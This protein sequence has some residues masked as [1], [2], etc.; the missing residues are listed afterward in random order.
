MRFLGALAAAAVVLGLVALRVTSCAPTPPPRPRPPAVGTLRPTPPPVPPA[1]AASPSCQDGPAAAAEANAVSLRTLAWSPFGRPEAGWETYAPLVARE[2]RTGC[3]P[4]TPGF[5]AALASWQGRQQMPA[6]GIM[7]AAVFARLKGIIQTRRPF[8][9][10]SAQ[11]ECPAPP[12]ADALAS[13]DR[14]EGYA[15][16]AI[17]LRPAALAAYRRMAA[18]ARAE[19]PAIAA[20][21]RDLTIFSGFRSP[22]YDAARCASEHNCNGLVRAVCSPHRTGL[23]MDLYVGQAPGFGPDSSADADRAFMSHTEAYR[24]LVA[25]ADRFGF[26]PYPFEPWHWEWTGEAP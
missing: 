26:V 8:V 1:P 7:T 21:P 14:G 6:D 19:D 16:K 23:A 12:S 11:H 10:L 22:A 5:A 9:R 13:A 18:A 24:W 17:L 3:A 20:D 4:D 15:G 2:L 25:N